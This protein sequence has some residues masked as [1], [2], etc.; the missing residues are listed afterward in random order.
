MLEQCKFLRTFNVCNKFFRMSPLMTPF[1]SSMLLPDDRVYSRTAPHLKSIFDIFYWHIWHILFSLLSIHVPVSNSWQRQNFTG[2]MGKVYFGVY[3]YSCFFPC[4]MQFSVRTLVPFLF[5]VYSCIII[6]IRI[7][8]KN[9]VF[10]LAV[11]VDLFR[12][13]ETY[14]CCVCCSIV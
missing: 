12:A 6:K 3:F 14:Q 10:L 4:G 8:L 5:L 7:F 9:C 2:F 1:I 13:Y 11:F